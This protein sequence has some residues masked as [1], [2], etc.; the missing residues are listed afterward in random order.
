[1]TKNEFRALKYKINKKDKEITTE[2]KA[3][4]RAIDQRMGDTARIKQ[5]FMELRGLHNQL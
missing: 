3:L 2:I 4:Q 1:M 5:K